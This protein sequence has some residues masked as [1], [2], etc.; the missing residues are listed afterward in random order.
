[1]FLRRLLVLLLAGLLA[2]RCRSLSVADSYI[3]IVQRGG[4]D[5]PDDLGLRALELL[6]M[7][8]S[9]LAPRAD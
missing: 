1:M 5:Q 2:G 6:V 8:L 7:E 4:L 3:G 9:S